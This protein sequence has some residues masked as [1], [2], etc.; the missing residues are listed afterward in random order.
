MGRQIVEGDHPCVSSVFGYIENNS[1]R[2]IIIGYHIT[3][4]VGLGM[5]RKGC[6]Q[7]QKQY[8]L[9][10]ASHINVLK[11]SYGPDL[12]IMVAFFTVAFVAL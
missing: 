11:V 10:W 3:D 7:E 1:F 2:P 9:D 4:A 6:R 8:Y 12:E 5:E